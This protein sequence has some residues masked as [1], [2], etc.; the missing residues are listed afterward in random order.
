VAALA[1]FCH[2]PFVYFIVPK[3]LSQGGAER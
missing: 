1:H 2:C 3:N